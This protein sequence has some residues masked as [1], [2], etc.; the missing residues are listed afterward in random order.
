M[1]RA[2]S[3]FSLSLHASAYPSTIGNVNNTQRGPAA[4]GNEEDGE[5]YT[6]Q[7]DELEDEDAHAEGSEEREPQEDEEINEEDEQSSEQVVL[8]ITKP[9]TRAAGSAAPA[10]PLSRPGE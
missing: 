4:R 10:S 2:A 3:W 9:K 7:Q 1:I 5:G 6:T 8:R